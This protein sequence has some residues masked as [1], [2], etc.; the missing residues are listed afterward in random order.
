MTIFFCHL[1]YVVEKASKYLIMSL[2]VNKLGNN[3]NKMSICNAQM[4]QINLALAQG[5]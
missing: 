5:L 1:Y 4:C 3:I 2:G